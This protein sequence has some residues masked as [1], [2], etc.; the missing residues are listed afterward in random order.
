MIRTSTF[1]SLASFLLAAPLAAQISFGGQ[2][3]GDKAEKRG[4][5]PAPVEHFPALDHDQLIA[6]DEARYASGVKGPFRFGF[7]HP[8][9][10]TMDNSGSWSVMPNG[11]RVWRLMLHCPGALSINL[12]WSDY[13]IPA[14]G[15]MF[16]YNEAGL[17]RG[18][19]T[20]QS[21]PGHTSFGTAP[22]AGD[23]ITV[24]YI[25]P[26]QAAGQGRLTIS[27]VVHGY[28]SIGMGVKG[29][30]ERDFGDSGDCNVNTICPEGD[31]WRDEIR[32][33]ARI[34]LGG[35]LCTGSLL[36]NCANDSTPYF[37]TARHCT[38]GNENSGSWVFL[39]NW[40]SPECDPTENAP[41]DHTITGCDKLIEFEGTDGSFLRL[42]SVPPEEFEPYF[43]GW[44]K[45]GAFPDTVTGIH[46]PRGDIKKIC[47]SF[48][49]I[50]QDNINA[51]TGP[52]DCWH[53]PQWDIGTT[54]QGSSGSALWDQNHRVIG[55]L[56]GGQASCSNNVNDYYGRFD[57]FY[58][59]ISEWLGECGD[60][61]DGFDPDAFIPVPLD[62]AVTSIAGVPHVTCNSS[63]IHPV[64]TLKNN[65]QGPITYANIHYEVDGASMGVIPW[66]GTI[67]PIQTT[68][69]ALPPIE[70]ASGVHQLKVFVTSPNNGVDTEPLNDAD[71]LTFIV[72]DP[73]I[74][75]V[76]QM[77][78]DRFGTETR[79]KIET[80]DGYPVYSGGPY[81]NSPNGYT[82]NTEVCLTHDCYRFTV[83]D[84]V[85]DGM[86]CDYGQ[87]SFAV[88]DT[89]GVVLLSGNGQFAFE[90]TTQLC[91]DWVGVP[92]HMANASIL[93]AP[94]PS[95]GRFAVHLP[96]GAMDWQLRAQ[97]AV[98]R[99]VWT[100]R[101]AAGLE[102]M[103]INL[104]H[105][106][107]GT[108]VLVAE[109]DGERAV[110][111]VVIQP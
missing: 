110:Q 94:N 102:R 86:C 63:T 82:V 22:L 24:E 31:D 2:P 8:A 108:Y 107:R 78:L 104:S 72:N 105:L 44:D 1:L 39:F 98:G 66:V 81:T 101:L 46:H 30:A 4:M 36:N 42:S 15:R 87:G 52:A 67:Q 28:R 97:D 34:M 79:W 100:G 37:L 89:L 65:G 54:E 64:V 76:I 106:A 19:F 91:V 41:M 59:H 99:V 20:A 35:G 17:V 90:T 6:E 96:S 77:N 60:T 84:A 56:Y 75:S 109:R 45:S 10:L 58:P 85:G 95:D 43:A 103:D 25:E 38:E 13:V 55:Q 93:V 69:V 71:S 92:T 53:A 48:G 73:G 26:M 68:N 88:H 83:M 14:G 33:V 21:N 62:A 40:E 61:L 57:L 47:S 27:T 49:P 9:N 29:G 50:G 70:M 12:Q 111:R 74:I 18:G 7:E 32:S 23:R 5:P 16:I 80:L 11:D 51:G 3:Y